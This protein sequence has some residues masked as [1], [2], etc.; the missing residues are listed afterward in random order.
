MTYLPEIQ[1]AAL[2]T[3]QSCIDGCVVIQKGV[4]WLGE[5]VSRVCIYVYSPRGL[6]ALSKVLIASGELAGLVDVTAKGA[7][8]ESLKNMRAFKDVLYA[9]FWVTS[10]SELIQEALSTKKGE[11]LTTEQKTI[12]GL[13]KTTKVLNCMGDWFEFFKFLDR[14]GVCS[15]TPFNEGAKFLNSLRIS[16]IPFS[17]GECVPA[18]NPFC[19]RPKD[20]FIFWSS[21][22]DIGMGMKEAYQ[23]IREGVSKGES[24]TTFVKK[25]D[26][27]TLAKRVSSL[28]KMILITFGNAGIG[29][30]IIDNITQL[31][32][33][34]KLI[35]ERETKRLDRLANPPRPKPVVVA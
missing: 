32:A 2:G 21:C 5:G 19:E 23:W 22:I 7:L 26:L 8:A 18:I 25:I 27:A 29:L 14:N 3:V 15:F 33:L 13:K 20:F 35:I 16:V 30:C 6:A 34:V 24:F 28:G 31:A 10:T 11:V 1:K 4:L 17:W 12:E 9:T